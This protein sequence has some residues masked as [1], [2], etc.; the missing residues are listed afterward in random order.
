MKLLPHLPPPSAACSAAK[1]RAIGAGGGGGSSAPYVPQEGPN[2]LQSRATI[3]AVD[4]LG[5]GEIRGLVNGSASI[6]IDG[7][8]IRNPDGS[9]NFNGISYDFNV[10]TPDQDP[11]DGF[12]YLE[13]ENAVNAE[14][15]Q[16]DP[17][18][19]TIHNPSIDG[20]RITVEFPRMVKVA[21]NGD[22]VNAE[23]AFSID[24]KLTPTSAWRR[25]HSVRINAKNTSP[26]ELSFSTYLSGAGPFSVRLTRLTAD[27]ES[28]KLH[29]KT[30]WKRYTELTRIR[31]YYPHSALIGLTAQA[32]HFTGQI[33]K[34]EYDVYG[35]IVQVPSN[36]DPLARTYAGL[37]DGTF[38]QA[39]TD[40]GAWIVYDILTNRRFG[41][42]A[43]IAPE[44]LDATK[45]ELYAVAQ[46][47]DELVPDGQG[48][49]E[50]RFTC[51]GVISKAVEAKRLLDHVL[52]NFQSALYYGGGT[53]TPYQERPTDPSLLVSNGNVIDGE[54]VYK[55][56]PFS[57]RYS[58]VA[59][60]FNDP[61]DRYK[62][63]IEL[64]V[65]DRLVEKYGYRQADR[66]AMFC[67]SRSQAQR[68]AKHTLFT[69]EYESDILEY[70]AGL[71][72]ALVAPGAVISQHDSAVVGVRS[73][74]RVAEY[75]E[76]STRFIEWGAFDREQA[77]MHPDV[78]IGIWEAALGATMLSGFGG[79]NLWRGEIREP[80][81]E[82]WQQ[83]A[84]AAAAIEPL[85]PPFDYVV[86]SDSDDIVMSMPV[87][88]QMLLD[89]QSGHPVFLVLEVVAP[90]GDV[91][92]A[93]IDWTG[94]GENPGII[95]NFFF[96]PDGF[97]DQFP[98]GDTTARVRF[99][100]YRDIGPLDVSEY[101]EPYDDGSVF[102][103]GITEPIPA[104]LVLDEAVDDELI[105][106]GSP[107]V[108]TLKADGTLQR[109]Y[110]D[111]EFGIVG[112]EIYLIIPFV[113]APAPGTVVMIDTGVVRSQDWRVRSVAEV[114][115]LEYRVIAH[116][117]NPNRYRSVE[118][119]VYIEQLPISLIPTGVLQPPDSV[120]LE[121]YLYQDNN[122]VRTALLVSVV[123]FG[124][125]P[126]ATYVNYEVKGP[127]DDEWR[128]L[129]G[130]VERSVEKPNIRIGE[131]Q[132]RAQLI[133]GTGALTSAWVESP[134]HN[135]LG[136][137]APPS[138]PQNLRVTPRPD[139]GLLIA[140]DAIPDLDR[141][142]YSFF[143]QNGDVI[144]LLY[145]GKA[146]EYL[147]DTAPVGNHLFY[148]QAHDTSDAINHGSFPASVEFEVLPPEAV[149]AAIVFD[150][151]GE[152]LL[153]DWTPAPAGTFAVA[154]YRVEILF[155]FAALADVLVDSTEF[156]FR[157]ST[158][159]VA[160]S[161]RIT[162]IDI[163]GNAGAAVTQA[164]EIMPPG[165]V[166][167]AVLVIDN[168]V[169]FRY[170]A[171]PG[172]LPIE[173]YEFSKGEIYSQ[174]AQIDKKA[175]TSTF[176]VTNEMVG[177][178]ITYWWVAVD[179][180]GNRSAPRSVVA[181][182]GEPKDF[183][184]Y[185]RYS[186]R[187][188][189]WVSGGGAE[190]FVSDNNF[191][192]QETNDLIMPVNVTEKFREHFAVNDWDTIA[193]Q[194]AAGFP[195]FAQPF[196][197]DTGANTWSVIIDYGV[198]ITSAT[199][200]TV[201]NARRLAGETDMNISIFLASETFDDDSSTPIFGSPQKG[202]IIQA[203]NFRYVLIQTGVETDGANVPNP[204][205]TGLFL[206]SDIVVTLST[207]STSDSGVA[208]VLA[209][210]A[211]GTAV[212]F[213]RTFLDVTQPSVTPI[214]SA[215][216]VATVDFDDVP[217]PTEFRVYLYDLTGA[218][219]S[220]QVKWSASGV[221]A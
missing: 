154:K 179:T 125:D 189:G 152:T 124:A 185:G 126:R 83:A 105:T 104:R 169:Q 160:F 206:I 142:E 24:T 66:V 69:Q 188:N 182:V 186:A 197:S 115:T 164:V 76:P 201:L 199:I 88:T 167:V 114:D 168:T 74:W 44:F 141:D 156:I 38:K 18:V 16:G 12:P 151:K 218:R 166:D 30:I 174:A 190:I 77:A 219:V 6:F 2:T 62:L 198:I 52:S 64:V 158:P 184:F 50:P 135:A 100:V 195:L 121:D 183:V 21:E 138:Q 143:W 35:R 31:Q 63:G 60:S 79:N 51:N 4:L 55:D 91:N 191:I 58:A 194:I 193:E 203:S 54:F 129:G 200:N 196:N 163:A 93:L 157:P 171:P 13:S 57:E 20:A 162:A 217:N 33:N 161:A 49:M 56:L 32:D 94:F 116:R 148:V 101:D 207:R 113:E 128:P 210:D 176:T 41:L 37:W 144:E 127:G 71:E 75:K 205:T 27:S 172:S 90:N 1:N 136:K 177:G 8:P 96:T 86:I 17:L 73:A 155:N 122:Q 29:N 181:R 159:A 48:G 139:T 87:E 45:W 95:D 34:R 131:W 215:A 39:W 84:A 46:F 173:F 85:A 153:I 202:D 211:G 70:R 7:T 192:I 220:G 67:T 165:A 119:S 53:V 5:E 47:N 36:Y 108:T 11:L 123:D 221:V 117:H 42:G 80:Y 208:D 134:V 212:P 15:F 10:G 213:N 112:A 97:W 216:R 106:G 204:R 132:A 130:S 89:N 187:E 180:A 92:S 22:T 209:T 133:D 149:D 59:M 110:I 82:G 175:G 120:F 68:A 72:H 111:P 170:S 81:I 25:Q 178:D 14:M 19:Q 145:R 118:R 99:V 40:N 137:T 147:W 109:S 65:D 3:R 214:G 28:D 43:E 146:T 107:L 140:A 102:S 23:V 78:I 61:D 9:L 26:A 98:D 103:F 150:F